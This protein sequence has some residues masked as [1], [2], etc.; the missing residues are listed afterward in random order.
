LQ[1]NFSRAMARNKP[2]DKRIEQEEPT[3]Y[4][5][6]TKSRAEK[7]VYQRLMQSEVECYLPLRRTR[8]KWSDRMK[9]VDEPL[10]KSYI[11]VRIIP[12]EYADV[13]KIEGIYKFVTFES[14]AVPIPESQINAIRLL[15]GQDAIL[16]VTTERI[17]QGQAIEVQAGPLI[18]LQGELVQYRGNRKVL[19]RIGEIGQGLLVTIDPGLLM[20]VR[21]P[22]SGE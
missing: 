11:F 1:R 5:C 6:Y 4:A 20:R 13:V 21:K 8:R 22:G 16:E 9:W 10:F 18:G 17:P 15:L 14:K 3:W 2:T 19:V 12:S 7:A